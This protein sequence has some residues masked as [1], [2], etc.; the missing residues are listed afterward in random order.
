MSEHKI[1]ELTRQRDELAAAL[2]K[3]REAL[4]AEV[5]YGRDVECLNRALRETADP[6]A[7][8]AARDAEHTKDLI[9]RI[10]ELNS[11]I[12][13]DRMLQALAAVPEAK[14]VSS[15]VR[16][17]LWWAKLNA[18]SP[19]Y[20]LWRDILSSDDVPL[21]SPGSVQLEL[22]SD[23]DEFYE[24]DLAQ[25]TPDQRQRLIGWSAQK[26][27]EP[28]EIVAADIDRNGYL[29]RTADVYIAFDLR[30]LI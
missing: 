24:L 12:D 23:K 5:R 3:A 9:D 19:R 20:S 30:M 27:G 4:V 14:A 17:P 10:C 29:I 7:I 28:E 1:E 26:F 8:L 16:S 18:H 15:V 11:W 6:S 25:V 13:R 21:K 2:D 22:T